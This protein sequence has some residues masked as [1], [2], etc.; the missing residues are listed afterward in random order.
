MVPDEI[1]TLQSPYTS[2]RQ[3]RDFHRRS[4]RWAVLVSHRR[5]GKT[6]ACVNDL[7]IG[8]TRLSPELAVNGRFAYIAPL[9]SQAKAVAWDYIKE[10]TRFLS[11][12]TYN[13]T[14]LRANLP[15][16]CQIRAFGAD[17]PDSLRGLYFDEVILDEFADMRPSLWG[18]IIRPTLADRHGRAVF[19]G[20]PKGRNEFWRMYDGALNGFLQEDG[21]RKVTDPW[22]VRM[23]RASESGILPMEEI[24]SMEGTMTQEEAE[25]EL[26]C[27]F[28]AAIRG[29]YYGKDMALA[30]KEKRIGEVPY[31]RDL[32]VYTAWD[33]GIRDA[34]AIWFWQHVGTEIHV[35]DYLEDSGFGLSHYAKAVQAKPYVYH[36]HWAPHDIDHQE[37]GSGRT[38]IEAAASV[39]INFRVVPNIGI[40]EGINAARATLGRCRFDRDKCA[41]GIEAL[42][43]Y[44]CEWDEERKCFLPRP[45]H[46]WSSHAADAFRYFALGWRE[47]NGEIE[48]RRRPR[49]S[50]RPFHG[51]TYM[52]A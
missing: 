6:V 33:I 42:R 22:F 28:D 3:F 38:R 39:G 20:T 52:S 24:R 45:K 13:E 25:Q 30:D 15:G 14:E 8:A 35:I 10:Y 34:T 46:D 36:E 50:K 11:G 27:S 47:E 19:I 2:R 48:E 31:K 18:M 26:E 21:T 51:E 16:G 29:A 9:L 12:T 7:I 4:E 37:W 1:I 41:L 5:A 17:N 32:P 40:L 23:M 49:Y 44:R 43:Q